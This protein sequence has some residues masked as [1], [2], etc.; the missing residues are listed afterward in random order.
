MKLV[1]C[2]QLFVAPWTVACQAPLSMEFSRQEYWGGLPFPSAGDLSDPGIEPGSLAL[3]ADPLLSE[4]HR[5][6]P[7]N[8]E[9]ILGQPQAT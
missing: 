5:K 7:A 6:V 1:S 9:R 2:V 4:L 8:L 3:Q